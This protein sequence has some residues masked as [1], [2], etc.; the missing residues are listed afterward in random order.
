MPDA[1]GNRTLDVPEM[2]KKIRAIGTEISPANLGA[3]M[4]L[5]APYHGAEPYHGVKVT[6]DIV[7]GPDPERNL[8]DLFLPAGGGKDLPVLI[9]L[10]GGGFVQGNRKSPDFPYYDNVMVWAVKNGMAGVN[11]TYRL[12]PTHKWPSGNEDVANVIRWIQKNAAANGMNAKRIFLMGQ[13]AGASHVAQYIAHKQFHPE[14]GHGLAGGLIISGIFEPNNKAY[15]GEDQAKWPSMSAMPGLVASDVPLLVTVAENDPPLFERNAMMLMN[16]LYE[17][18]Q[19]IP[20][21]QRM[22]GHNHISAMLHV[23]LEPED[24]LGGLIRDFIAT[25]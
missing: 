19:R 18:D 21:F 9:Y 22:W 15:F 14:G 3:A 8:L 5:Y 13:S 2:R 20:W 25:H 24:Q 6:R 7:Y 17:R 16:A 11:M 4:K 23:G 10:H 12:A 1:A